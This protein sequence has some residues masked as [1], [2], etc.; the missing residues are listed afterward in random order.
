M[1]KGKI[2]GQIS[3][4]VVQTRA[5]TELWND[6]SAEFD[7][8][9]SARFE[10]F[11]TEFP[12]VIFRTGPIPIYDCSGLTFASRRTRLLDMYCEKTCLEEDCYEEVDFRIVLPGDIVIYHD[13]LGGIQHSGIVLRIDIDELGIRNHQILSKW[14]KGPETI[15]GLNDC[16]YNE[17][18]RKFYRITR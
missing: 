17:G 5:G 14:G 1:T 15:H 10:T 13:N 4:I 3:S 7:I 2:I 8:F 11:K 18:K 16:P 6:Q 12:D 9:D